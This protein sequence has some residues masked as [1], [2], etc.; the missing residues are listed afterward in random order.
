[1][2][3]FWLSGRKPNVSYVFDRIY[4]ISRMV[5]FWLSGRKPKN[6]APGGLSFLIS[7]REMRKDK[8]QS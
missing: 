3:D 6:S 2:V 7:I 4:R 8:Q 5:D 1:M